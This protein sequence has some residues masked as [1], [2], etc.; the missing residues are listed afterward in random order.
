MTFLDLSGYITLKYWFWQRV[1]ISRRWNFLWQWTKNV[2]KLAMRPKWS[3]QFSFYYWKQI[4]IQLNWQEKR[5]KRKGF[6]QLQWKADV[7]A[8]AVICFTAR[9]SKANHNLQWPW[10][11]QLCSFLILNLPS[12]ARVSLTEPPCSD[13]Y[14]CPFYSDICTHTHTHTINPTH[15][16]TK[17]MVYWAWSSLPSCP[18]CP[19]PTSD[20]ASAVR[21][22]RSS[23]T[24]DPSSKWDETPSLY[25]M[26]ACVAV[27]VGTMGPESAGLGISNADTA[28]GNV[29]IRLQGIPQRPEARTQS[30]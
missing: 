27:G 26:S 11:F 17:A 6:V 8:K 22:F 4:I 25:G 10:N 2:T 13:L 21:I 24:G 20:S 9:P 14:I 15:P 7:R 29:C 23:A 16:H 1:Q 18:Y 28:D 3:L 5:K 19:L 30:E 12:Q